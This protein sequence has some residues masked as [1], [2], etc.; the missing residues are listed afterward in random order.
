M[1][2]NHLLYYYIG[3]ETNNHVDMKSTRSICL[4]NY[5]I[6]IFEYFLYVII[7]TAALEDKNYTDIIYITLNSI[8][9]CH[10]LLFVATYV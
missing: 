3:V 9:I 7:S 6:T 4:T 5:A 2:L 10:G 8:L 1:Q